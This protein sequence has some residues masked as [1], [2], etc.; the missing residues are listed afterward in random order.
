MHLEGPWGLDRTPFSPGLQQGDL[1][2]GGVCLY[3][4]PSTVDQRQESDRRYA[5][6][7]GSTVEF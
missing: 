4:T 2:C 6:F 3:Q 1:R 5:I 7:V